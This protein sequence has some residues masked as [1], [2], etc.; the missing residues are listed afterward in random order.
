MATPA[1]DGLRRFASET[2]AAEA[3]LQVFAVVVR[4]L[5]ARRDI[6]PDNDTHLRAADQ[7]FDELVVRI[8]V[9]TPSRTT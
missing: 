7:L 4:V 1:S 9:L 8:G 5:S 2:G 3:V 6:G